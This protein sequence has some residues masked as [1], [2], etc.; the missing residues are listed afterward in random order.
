MELASVLTLDHLQSVSLEE[1]LRAVLKQKRPLTV[2]FPD[3]EA[4]MVQPKPDLSPLP[5]LDG[6]VPDGWREAIYAE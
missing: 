3:G 6:Y 4:V 1:F 5:A 2:Q